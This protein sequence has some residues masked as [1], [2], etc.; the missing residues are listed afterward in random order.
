ME[1]GIYILLVKQQHKYGAADL[2]E[3][4][5]ESLVSQ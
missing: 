1:R 3:E 2:G 5:P 4:N